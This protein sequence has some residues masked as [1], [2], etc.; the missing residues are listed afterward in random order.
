M[1]E[2]Q[3]SRKSVLVASGY[4]KCRMMKLPRLWELERG[5]APLYVVVQT[6]TFPQIGRGLC[7]RRRLTAAGH[8]RK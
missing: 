7:L 4:S 8:G 1:K 2:I 3:E 5:L 6:E